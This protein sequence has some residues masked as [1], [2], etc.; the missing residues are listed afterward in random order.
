MT[1]AVLF[2]GALVKVIMGKVSLG[3]VCSA[4]G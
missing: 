1:L 3:V 2:Y 4:A